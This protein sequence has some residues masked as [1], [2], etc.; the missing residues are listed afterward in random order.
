MAAPSL[1]KLLTAMR[2]I[3]ASDLHL[4][5]GERPMYRIHGTLKEAEHPPL[6]AEDMDRFVEEAVPKHAID[7]WKT[8]WSADFAMAVDEMTRFRVNVFRSLGKIAF[9]FRILELEPK[10][11]ESLKLPS[12]LYDIAEYRRGMVLVTGPTGSGKTTTLAA[13]IN[14]VNESR[15][16]HIVTIEDPVEY[17]YRDKL[18]RIDQRQLHSDTSSFEHALRAAMRQDPDV[19]LVG[20]M[21]DRETIILAL[22]ASQTGHL[23]FS[24]LHTTN[25]IE[26]ISRILKYFAKDEQEG[27]RADLA[28][29]LKSILCQRLVPRPNGGRA[30]GLEIL[31]VNDLIARLIREQRLDDMETIMRSGTD[32]M[33]TFD[34]ALAQLVQD[35]MISM[36][37]GI[38]YADDPPAF[39]RLAQGTTAG[40]DSAGLIGAF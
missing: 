2:K 39:K 32:G 11:F 1:T 10:T 40:S 18:S 30:A 33:Q 37:T 12:V 8:H 17:I 22:K 24:T 14:Q 23:V 38:H 27:M 31:I 26:T 34:K 4:K 5:E 7:D 36:E 6:T 13:F 35:E 3:D 9:A 16:E 25:A 29:A 28:V 15:K 19:I 20:E 21:R